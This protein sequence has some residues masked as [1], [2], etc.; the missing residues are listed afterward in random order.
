MSR[1]SLLG[2]LSSLHQGMSQLLELLPSDK[3]YQSSAP[4]LAP[5]A[6]YLGHAA[7]LESHWL[8]EFRDHQRSEVQA[9]EQAFNDESE[10]PLSQ[11]ELLKWVAQIQDDNIMLLANPAQLLDHPTLSHDR[12]ISLILQS[13]AWHYEKM[14]QVIRCH[15]H[16]M[17]TGFKVTTPLEA[18]QPAL[19]PIGVSQGHY[20]IGA[21]AD[22]E[23]YD[24]ELPTQVVQLSN[25]QID[26]HSVTNSQYLSFIHN[27]AYQQPELWSQ[28]GWQWLQTS[29]PHPYYW[30]QDTSGNWYETGVN[31]PCE[32]QPTIPVSGISLHEAA[33]YA[34]WVATQ[35]EQLKGAVV[36]H[37]YQWE[38]AV[39]TGIIE[40]QISAWEWCA[41]AFEAY[42]DFKPDAYPTFATETFDA[43]DF[44]IR[45]SSLHTPIALR[46][47][48]HRNH[49][50]AEMK[51]L[52]SGIR[53]VYP[54]RP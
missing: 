30:K 47:I 17:E 12:L 36:Q 9:V 52:F 41:N 44:V 49:A 34:Q 53:L 39:R 32:L 25:F 8:D 29:F 26:R 11:P 51:H 21:K 31:G 23:A 1:S 46:R 20:R 28:Q 5:L 15:Q 40:L 19:D 48:S 6:W 3:N 22:F 35:N 16:R 14:I 54:P 33:A 7:Y 45:G 38:A 10:T 50:P 24:N 37:E 13:R 42:T 27:G 4:E 18:S 2:Q 43:G